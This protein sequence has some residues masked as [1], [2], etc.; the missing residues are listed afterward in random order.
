MVKGF[1]K[2]GKAHAQSESD[3]IVLRGEKKLRRT[4][5]TLEEKAAARIALAG[6]RK[7]VQELAKQMKRDIPGRFKTARKSIGWKATKGRAASK[8]NG[9]QAAIAKAGVGVGM[10]RQKRIA[11]IAKQK[12]ARAG[13]PGVGIGVGNFHWYIKGTGWKSARVTRS[14]RDLGTT[15]AEAPGFAGKAARK[16]KGKIHLAGLRE[17]RKRLTAEVAKAKR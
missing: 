7:Q 15:R 1:A 3:A 14:G 2:I 6:T 16:A 17:Y 10:K 8:R 4:L 9:K 5:K 11:L 13:R 12:A